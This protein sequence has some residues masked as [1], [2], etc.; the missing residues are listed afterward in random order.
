[1]YIL[2]NCSNYIYYESSFDTLVNRNMKSEPSFIASEFDITSNYNCSKPMSNDVAPE[3][4]I[5]YIVMEILVAIF[6]V[7]G[8]SLVIIVFCT[9]RKLRRR[10]NFYIISLAFADFLAASIGIPAAILISV[11]IPH[12]CNMCL[13]M[14]SSLLSFFTISI[15]SL[16]LVSCD[17]FMSIIFP[18]KYCEEKKNHIIFEIVGCWLLGFF[19]G[20]L[21]YIWHKKLPV[22]RCLYQNVITEGL[23]L[24][25]FIVVIIIPMLIIFVIYAMIYRVVLHQAS[26]GLPKN[27]YACLFTTS[28]LVVLCTISIFCLVAVSIDRY[29]A[30]LHPLAYS[31]NVR[32]KTAIGIISL[33]W[34]FGS[35]IGFLPVFG[36]H[37]GTEDEQCFFTEIMDYNYLVFLYFTTIIT[38]SIILAVFYGLIYRVILKQVNKTSSSLRLSSTGLDSKVST[39][40]H[41]SSETHVLRLLN[42]AAQKREVK[43]TQNLSIIV[44]FFMICW[45]PLYTINCIN[46]FCQEC[47][48]NASITYF[49]IILSH[50]NSAINPLL[51]AYHLKD[52]RGALIRLFTCN[53]VDTHYRP[54]FISQQ[55]QRITSQMNQRRSYQPRTY[56]DSPVYKRQQYQMKTITEGNSHI[57]N[58]GD[59]NFFR[60]TDL[61]ISAI[62]SSPQLRRIT[63]SQSNRIYIIS[64]NH[65]KNHTVE[66][67]PSSLYNNI[68]NRCNQEKDKE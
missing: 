66:P 52:F 25:R 36:W 61:S 50:L 26:V 7:L 5:L 23:Q 63:S 54:S 21:P 18:L 12:N 58:N 68:V 41:S 38:P 8:N 33:C 62:E 24:F 57:P 15:F 29:W 49:G 32:T 1:M 40:K 60:D 45:I 2:S 11:G 46:A 31:R 65:E 51:Y 39:M 22:N 34:V 42:S 19:I 4:N 16:V 35:V 28:S 43:A 14:I 47:V 37:N 17:R 55:Q 67:Q 30:I 20:F 3:V 44:A 48:R 53:N 64:D 13:L 27:L 10:T 6:G 9:T 59:L 56:I